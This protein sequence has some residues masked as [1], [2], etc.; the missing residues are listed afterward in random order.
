MSNLT[1]SWVTVF[2][3]Y[4][5]FI[6]AC[7]IKIISFQTRTIVCRLNSTTCLK[8]LTKYIYMCVC[9]IMPGKVK[10]QHN[11]SQIIFDKKYLTF[12]GKIYNFACWK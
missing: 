1:K 4:T 7:F 8:I 9:V 10:L 5:L 11:L 2:I 6:V 12:I 3:T